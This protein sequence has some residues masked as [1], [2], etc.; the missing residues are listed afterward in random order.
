MS[1]KIGIL[2]P[3]GNN[4]NP[5]TNEPYSDNYKELAKNWSNLPAYRHTD[6]ILKL[7]DK[8]NV[9]L[10]ISS[11]GSG[12]TVL[13]PKLALH[14]LNYN[15]KIVVTMP[16]QNIVRAAAEYAAATLDVKLGKDVGYQFRGEGKNSSKTKILYATDGTLVSQFSKDPLIKQ[17]D[18]VI[19][20]EAHERK[21]QID[22]LLYL[23][24]QAIEKRPELKLIIMSATVNES[25]FSKYFAKLKFAS[26]DVK[27][28]RTYSVEDLYL[29]SPTT[30]YLQ[31]GYDTIKRIVN[32]DDLTVEGAHDILFFVPSIKDTMK[33]CDLVNKD[34]LDLYCVRVYAGMDKHTQ[35]IAQD[36]HKYKETGKNRK[37][38][39]ATNVVES[40]ITIDGIKFVID[41]GLEMLSSFDPNLL[42]KKLEKLFI[43]K[44]QS[45]QR[46]GRA[47]RTESGFCYN[48]FTQS[49]YDSMRA[50]PE[51]SIRTSNILDECVKL[52]GLDVINDVKTLKRV[53]SEFIEPPDSSYI[54]AAIEQMKELNVIDDNGKPTDLCKCINDIGMET[55]AVI[56]IIAGYGYN[57]YREVLCIYI[58]LELCKGRISE[59][60]YKPSKGKAHEY[61]E[62]INYFKEKTGDHI[63]LLKIL[64]QFFTLYKK[65]EGIDH[66][67]RMEW[68]KSRF[69]RFNVLND[70]YMRFR[71]I[72]HKIKDILSNYVIPFEIDQ[73]V[74]NSGIEQ[75][76]LAAVQYGYRNQIAIRK[77]SKYLTKKSIDIVWDLSGDTFM[78]SIPNKVIYHEAFIMDK[79]YVLNICSILKK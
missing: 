28:E 79:K 44:A 35:I 49:Q 32:T 73:D 14:S 7:I 15:G 45:V 38:V 21:I 12:K 1:T 59:I 11:T 42:A 60:F 67:G 64:H 71:A 39:M 16:K 75:R 76:V 40:S 2:D 70:A 63:S 65:S 37:L 23:L 19:I 20:D 27:G 77:N 53:L 17:Y 26:L 29:E 66:Q 24:K 52:L 33:I 72:N 41:S 57:C 55:N 34:N 61:S 50:Y 68:C 78:T 43:T 3:E 47:G 9:V 69:I 13:L 56:A 18:I 51:P 6:K 74:K 10:I 30:K 4:A 62:I 36:K 5:L 22:F 8:N 54:D 25:V 48:L 46:A 58:L 31:I